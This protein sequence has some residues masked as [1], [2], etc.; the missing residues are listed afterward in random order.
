MLVLTDC[1][2]VV[3]VDLPE[4]GELRLEGVHLPAGRRRFGEDP[5]DGP[6]IWTTDDVLVAPGLL[7]QEVEA[8]ARERGLSA[9]ILD[10]LRAGDGRPWESNE[11]G[12]ADGGDVAGHDPWDVFRERWKMYVPLTSLPPQDRPRLGLFERFMPPVELDEDDSEDTAL[13]LEKVSP[14]GVQFPGLALAEREE[15]SQ[16]AV[17]TALQGAA[18]GRIGLVAVER[19]ADILFRI[20]W[21]GASNHF[22]ASPEE[23]KEGPALLSVMMRSWEDRFGARLLRL[24]FDTMTF[25]VSR[26]PQTEASALAVAAEHFAFA[27]TDGFQAYAR[28]SYVDSI[29]S[30]AT[31]IQGSLRWMFWWD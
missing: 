13:F 17:A 7:W 18:P 29:R 21:W 10:D 14:W 11:L 26:P 19:A 16:E 23:Q 3:S 8:P 31:V 12:P 24:G 4:D 20:G 5:E 2:L 25:L 22:M 9:V 28:E 27:G 6:V 30:L 15:V 1:L